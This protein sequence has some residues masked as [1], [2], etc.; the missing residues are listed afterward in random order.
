MPQ[1][2]TV[3]CDMPDCSSKY[4]EEEHGVGFPG[5]SILQGICVKYNH[6][7]LQPSDMT[8]FICPRHTRLIARAIEE[9]D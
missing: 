8:S 7:P 2:R 4:T 6:E 1:V 5:W 9:I 3:M